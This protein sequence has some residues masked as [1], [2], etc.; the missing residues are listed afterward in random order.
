M[1]SS[2]RSSISSALDTPKG[3][4]AFSADADASG[5]VPAGPARTSRRRRS[6]GPA[7]EENNKLRSFY[8]PQELWDAVA[9]EV[10]KGERSKTQVIVDALRTELDMPEDDHG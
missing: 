5:G 7:W 2:R 3:R 6:K 10:A 9:D 1:P 4:D 8:C